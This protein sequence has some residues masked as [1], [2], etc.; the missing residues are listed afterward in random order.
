MKTMRSF[1]I[2]ATPCPEDR[3]DPQ[4]GAGIL[5]VIAVLGLTFALVQGTVFYRAKSSA[6]FQS[7]EKGKIQAQQAADAGVEANIAD[8]GSRRIRVVAGMH[9][10]VTYSRKA[11][12]NS[13]FTTS[14]T[15]QGMG[16][17]GDTIQLVS[18]GSAS[19]NTQTVRAK[20]RLKYY[21]DTN[22]VLVTFVPPT[23]V[24]T[25]RTVT[26]Q[27]ATLD[28]VVQNPEE[29]PLLNATAAYAACMSSSDKK[30][31]VCHIPGGNPDNR[32]VI[33]INKNAIGTHIGH[34]GDYITTDGTCDI[35]NPR[36]EEVLT[37][38]THVVEDRDTVDNSVYAER[39]D[40][41]SRVQ[42]LSWK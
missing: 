13:A 17:G 42:I 5:G 28:T 12:G 8:L 30:C 1:G 10:Y 4:A 27:V 21:L 40:T 7:S 2:P 14:L 18:Q 24:I 19:S 39:I 32:H 38:V 41:T 9:D 34:H 37:T 23:I 11:I 3:P 33:N 35:Y 29:M 22:R 15:T 31:D 26:E 16:P 36:I 6:R 20:M 25:P